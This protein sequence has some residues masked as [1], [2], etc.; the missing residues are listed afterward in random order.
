MK[1]Q[2][3]GKIKT[4]ALVLITYVF[5]MFQ[6][7]FASWFLFY[8]SLVFLVYE[9]IAYYLMFHSLEVTREI[10][11]N[12]LQEGD[13]VVVTVRLRRRFW[14]P[15]GWNMVTEPL[16]D[17]L[18]GVFEPHRQLLFPWLKREI[19]FKYVI[20]S[21]PRGHYR[22]NDCVVSGG[23]FFG[24]VERKKTFTLS[25]DFL[26]YPTYKEMTQWAL[27][28]GSFSGTVHVAHRRSDDV[29]AVRG[30]REYQR[31]DRLSQIH[32]RASARGTGL[33]TKEFEHQ[34]MNQVLFF[35]DVEKEHYKD[36]PS[37]LFEAA[38]KLTA[39]LTAYAN[40]NQY[41]Y[42]LV[43]KQKERVVI[44]P[45]CSHTHFIR[46]F[47]HLARVM[48]EGTD[49]F[50][51]LV[52]REA[53][54]QPPGVTLVVITPRID[55]DMIARLVHL[56]QK[57]RHIHLLRMHAQAIPTPEEKQAMQMLTASKVS[58]KTVHLDDVE[59]TSKIGGA[60]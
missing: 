45:S 17:R 8:S 33:K 48:P 24:F 14:F 2:R 32:W 11:R 37:Q 23:D 29:A 5:A 52:G 30:V 13:D 3:Y 39:S 4:A 59:D 10:D 60:S 1:Q 21:L 25:N 50:S 42:G 15:L 44:H 55:K 34:A 16:P 41:H 56:S 49:Y 26:V 19:E 18:A 7:G 22:L 38:V 31:G 28:D 43:Y 20:P 9:L 36:Q 35:L 27:G 47:D 12:R 40:R 53:L 6:G 51:R 54:E 58:C 57:G 46:I